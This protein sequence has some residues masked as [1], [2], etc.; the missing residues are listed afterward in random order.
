VII[1]RLLYDRETGRYVGETLEESPYNV[2]LVNVDSYLEHLLG[3]PLDVARTSDSD[4]QSVI[5]GWTF[6]VPEG[7]V[8]PGPKDRFEV[9]AIPMVRRSDGSLSSAFLDLA[10]QRAVFEQISQDRGVPL[11]VVHA[12]PE[13]WTPHS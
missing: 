4:G 7:D 10:E 1:K 2:N 13:E 3:E 12:K 5:I 8:V 6:P 9:V 11:Q